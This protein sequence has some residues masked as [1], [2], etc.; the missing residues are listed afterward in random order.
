MKFENPDVVQLAATW[1]D[2]S[3]EI[4]SYERRILRIEDLPPVAETQEP[5]RYIIE[6]ELPESSIVAL[7]G[8]SGSGKSTVATAWARDSIAKGR[9]VLILDRENSRGVA[10]DRMRRLGLA[11]SPMLRWAG[12]WIRDETP[13]PE[14]ASVYDWVQECDP[15]PLVVIDSLTAFFEGDE[16]S[17]GDMRSFMNSARRLADLGAT[18]VIIHHNGKGTTARV[19]RGSSDFKAAVDQLFLVTNHSSDLKLDRLR[20]QCDKSRYGFFGSLVYRYAGGGLVRDDHA[21][22]PAVGVD[23]QLAALLRLHPGVTK[24][25]FEKLSVNAGLGRRSA[26]TFLTEGALGGTVNKERGARRAEHYS[27]KVEVEHE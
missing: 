8:D 22:A 14:S 9:P 21:E 27:L 26:R 11:D 23:Q 15:K 17:A 1:G 7:T 6:P 5:I 12:G 24:D 18:V 19:F 4:G 13:G 20:L 3:P 16:N 10:I 25:A 2:P